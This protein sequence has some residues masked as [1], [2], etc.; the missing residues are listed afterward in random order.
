MVDVTQRSPLAQLVDEVCEANGWSRRHVARR[1]Q[2]R[3]GSISASRLGQLLSEYPLKGIQ[4]DKIDDLAL[5][6]GISRDRVAVAVIQAMGFRV[7]DASVS[8]A[9]AIQRDPSLSADTKHALL[10][11]L[12]SSPEARQSGGGERAERRGS[13]PIAR[14]SGRPAKE[15]TLGELEER[16]RRQLGEARTDVERQQLER[17]LEELQRARDS[18]P[19]PSRSE[20]A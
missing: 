11:I 4:A 6:L 18:V 12:R 15:P 17:M 9:E 13:A 10:A 14:G 19:D 16:L 2:Q 1:A 3:G 20:T 8:P 7:Q 5:G